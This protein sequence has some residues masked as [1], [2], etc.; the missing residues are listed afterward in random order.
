MHTTIILPDV[1]MFLHAQVFPT[2][3]SHL[4]VQYQAVLPLAYR[5][6]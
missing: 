6:R 4:Q 1:R 5:V 2:A 3:I